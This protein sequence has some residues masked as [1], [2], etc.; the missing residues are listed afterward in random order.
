MHIE[1]YIQAE[2]KN[3]TKYHIAF[4][5]SPDREDILELDFSVP[6]SFNQ[7]TVDL[8][9]YGLLCELEYIITCESDL[10]ITRIS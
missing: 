6:E 10:T 7:R 2:E 8:I 4:K 1:E 3:R 5:E 9:A